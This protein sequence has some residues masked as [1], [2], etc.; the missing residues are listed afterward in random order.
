MQTH[1]HKQ[2]ISDSK[3][4]YQQFERLLQF[5]STQDLA[6]CAR[7]L[8]LY[9]AMYKHEFGELPAEACHSYLASEEN[10]ANDPV[11]AQIF[12]AGLQEVTSLLT[13]IQGSH[14][15]NQTMN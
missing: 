9:V 3:Q 14:G 11:I 5:S 7:L 15:Q 13:L 1:T 6:R 2:S 12:T 8:G 4:I 10:D